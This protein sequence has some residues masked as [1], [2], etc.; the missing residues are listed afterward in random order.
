MK[1]IISLLALSLTGC[2]MHNYASVVQCNTNAER[3][4]AL[5]FA[6]AMPMAVAAPVTVAVGLGTVVGGGYYAAHNASC[7]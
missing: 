3:D 7:N 2:N 1:N 6:A 4:A 5:L